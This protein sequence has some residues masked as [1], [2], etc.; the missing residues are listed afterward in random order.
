M[1]KAV[2]EERIEW[3]WQKA[4]ACQGEDE[5]LLC[6]VTFH[7]SY[8]EET[9]LLFSVSES[10]TVFLWQISQ[11]NQTPGTQDGW[12]EEMH[13]PVLFFHF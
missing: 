6:Y 1:R 8:Q 4:S 9:Y 12:P 2:R 13:L 11:L 5:I 10:E 7:I 3:T